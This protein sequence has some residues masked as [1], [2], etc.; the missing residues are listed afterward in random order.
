MM[1]SCKNL[2]R[3]P[4]SLASAHITVLNQVSVMCFSPGI[5]RQTT[6]IP[7][8]QRCLSTSTERLTPRKFKSPKSE[9]IFNKL[10][11]LDLAEVRL[12]TELVAQKLGAVITK[13]DRL[14][15]SSSAS[16]SSSKADN[17]VSNEEEATMKKPEKS[18]FDL[19]LI[20]FDE[21]SKIKVIK[22]IRAITNL[23]LKEAKDLVEGVPKVVK[24]DMKK[25][26]AES[27]KEKLVAVGATVEII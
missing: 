7:S 5:S 9:A 22:E 1:R 14:G 11:Q 18:A 10:T 6:L 26:E 8:Q 3:K 23:G 17:A 16:T 20:A 15:R 25:E 12:I 19:K 4:C 2:W 27:L 24:K 13:N 21:K